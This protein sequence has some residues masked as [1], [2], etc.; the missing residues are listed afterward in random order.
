MIRLRGFEQNKNRALYLKMTALPPPPIRRARGLL[1]GATA[2]WGLSFPLMRGL[3]L[4]QGVHARGVPFPALGAAD[5]AVRFLLAALVL[6]PFYGRELL[7]ISR[8]EWSQAGGLAFFAGAGLY[9]QTVGLMWTDASVSAFLT[10]LY[11]LIVPIIVAVRD[12]RWPTLRV[13]TACLMV[14]LGAALLSPG[15]LAHFALAF[16][17]GLIM[18]SATFFAGQ[19]VWVE[20]PRY[21]ANRAGVV[22]LLMFGL[23]GSFFA[24]AYP[25]LGGTIAAVPTIFATPGLIALM[26]ATVLF[27]TVINFF[28]MNQWQRWVSATEAGLIYCLEPVIATSLAAFLPGW[29]SIAAGV[30]YANEQLAWTLLAGGAL[31]ITATILVAT[32]RRPLL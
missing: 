5:M 1:I 17:E 30:A 27:C 11:T 15:L 9:L 12:R 28:I 21:A 24:I 20:R 29:I 18:L 10:Q 23:M 13:V 14:L 4:A 7:S 19:I 6:L 32:E 25:V 16:G 22:T 2:L 26:L 3:E 31:I 8:R